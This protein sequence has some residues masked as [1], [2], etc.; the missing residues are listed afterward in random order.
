MG[1]RLGADTARIEP[2]G[3]EVRFD[4]SRGL[5]PDDGAALKDLF[6]RHKLLLFRD[7]N[8]TRDQQFG[9]LEHIGPVDRASPLDYVTPDDVKTIAPPVFRHRIILRPE[10]EIEGLN[11][12]AVLRRWPTA[13]LLDW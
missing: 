13:R 2:F 5:T 1:Q 12:D 8:L 3:L 11:A 4:L 10:A 6:Y 9:V 7:Q